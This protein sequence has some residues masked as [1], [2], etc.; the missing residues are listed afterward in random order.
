[1]K[2]QQLKF[3]AYNDKR[4]NFKSFEKV[5]VNENLGLKNSVNM[6]K[7][8]KNFTLRNFS[9]LKINNY[10]ARHKSC[11]EEIIFTDGAF[12]SNFHNIFWKNN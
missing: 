2:L 7:K 8:Y 9:L 1:M 11:F 4:V 10:F 12:K 3:T 5:S 6:I